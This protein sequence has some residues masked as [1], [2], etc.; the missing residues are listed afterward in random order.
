VLELHVVDIVVAGLV[1][2]N[3]IAFRVRVVDILVAGL[4]LSNP[5][6]FRVRVIDIL[7]AARHRGRHG[8]S[9]KS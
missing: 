7:V 2:S 3:P 5:I 9:S 8:G 4:V 1:L 6:A